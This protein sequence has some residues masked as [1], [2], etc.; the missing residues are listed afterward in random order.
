MEQR[1]D[2]YNHAKYCIRYHIIL[3]VKYHKRIL[4]H[5][6]DDLKESFRRAEI[7]DGRWTIESMETDLKEKKDHHVHL[8]VKSKPDVAPSVI[9][10]ELKQFST[11]DMWNTHHMLLSRNFW[12]GKHHL[13]TRGYFCVT[14]GDASK[15]TIRKYIETQG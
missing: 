2:T 11:I 10:S 13:W 5:M 7:S 6:I 14:I 3:S 15:D 9:V 4:R 12:N 8:M 1:Y